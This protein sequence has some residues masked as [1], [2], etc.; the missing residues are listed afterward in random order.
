MKNEQLDNIVLGTAGLAGIWGPVDFKESED[1][2]LFAL[3]S[4]IQYFDTSPAYANAES[5]LGNA[6]HRWSGKRP[7]ISTKA[8]KSKATSPDSVAYDFSPEGLRRSVAESLDTLKV[9]F[10]DVLFLHDPSGMQVSEIPAAIETLQEI[11]SMGWAKELGVGGNYGIQFELFV[12]GDIFNYFMGYNRFNIINQ[13]AVDHEFK[14][15]R[16]EKIKIWQASPLYM[17]LLGSKFLNYIT[18]LPEWIPQNDIDAAK[19]LTEFCKRT[20][21]SITGLALQYIISSKQVDKMVLGASSIRE[22]EQTLEFLTQGP[23]YDTILSKNFK[24]L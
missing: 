10:I 21:V 11:K 17:G 1:A 16:K 23:S 12:R 20:N 3:E 4:G 18:S 22:L 13:S 7:Y 19:Q 2:I 24:L 6:I 9:D 14:Q 15:L 5:I 8:G